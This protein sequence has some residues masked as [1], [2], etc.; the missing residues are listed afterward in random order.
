MKE[1]ERI[2][3]IL[4]ST[5]PS[6]GFGSV[7]LNNPNNEPIGWTVFKLVGG[8][9]S[10]MFVFANG[11][12]EGFTGKDK[13]FQV[14]NGEINE[15]GEFYYSRDTKKRMKLTVGRREP[16]DYELENIGFVEYKW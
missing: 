1:I 13:L 10:E 2:I 8:K 15:I 6:L 14:G 9:P 3:K 11:T 12:Y 4:Q 16:V 5:S 7:P